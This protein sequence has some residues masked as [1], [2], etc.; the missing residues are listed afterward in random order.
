VERHAF[1][2]AFNILESAKNVLNAIN[3]ERT[4]FWPLIKRFG[5]KQPKSLVLM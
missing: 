4:F 3:V 1:D 2:S 5:C